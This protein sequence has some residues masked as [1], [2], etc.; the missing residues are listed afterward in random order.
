MGELKFFTFS[1]KLN[2]YIKPLLLP[3]L[4]GLLFI[5]SGCSEYQQVLKSND[6]EKKLKLAKKL[7]KEEE[8]E[9]ALPLFS[10][11]TN[12]YR[13]TK[14]GKKVLYWYA[15]CHYGV[16]SYKVAAFRF[17]N[18]YQTY[19]QSDKAEEAL[20]MHAYCLYLQSPRVE[21]VQ[22]NTRKAIKAFKLFITRYPNS[23]KVSKCNQFI[24]ELRGK[25]KE[26]AYK[27]AYLWYKIYDFKAAITAFNNLLEKYPDIKQR[28]KVEFL[29]LKS[30]YKVA[31]KSIQSKKRER[32]NRTLRAY[33]EFADKYPNS[34]YLDEAKDIRDQ[35][36]SALKQL[37]L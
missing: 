32:Y 21:L 13:G 17:K 10:D 8:Y 35:T 23:E 34:E 24:D 1:M 30:R 36:K 7:Y 20:Y 26:K 5:V 31:E 3:L 29:I 15:N 16:G 22:K 6:P 2:T 14:K 27:K 4:M 12:Y 37:N 25:I 9:K 11:V 33:K 19:R 28:E 18:Y